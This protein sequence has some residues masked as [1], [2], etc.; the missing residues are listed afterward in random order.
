MRSLIVMSTL[1]LGPATLAAQE[2]IVAAG[3]RVRL[4]TKGL[5]KVEGTI[6]EWRG[7][8]IVLRPKKGLLTEVPMDQ[9][10]DLSVVRGRRPNPVG[11]AVKGMV[12]GGAAGLA[13]FGALCGE[14]DID[15]GPD[16]GGPGV[17]SWSDAWFLLMGT[18][19]L[20]V[21]GGV[22]GLVTGT[23]VG[24]DAWRPVAIPAARLSVRP[25]NGGGVGVGFSL[26]F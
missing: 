18:G 1:L 6:T 20:A 2:P 17:C 19:A 5:E 16:D 7:D 22:V 8:T 10:S 21:A 11:G 25:L 12:V 14:E 23:I 24:T 9:V 13:V 15:P 26:R 3:S 4:T